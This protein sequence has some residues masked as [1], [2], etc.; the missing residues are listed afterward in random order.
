M[1][2][3]FFTGFAIA[4]LFFAALFAF[5]GMIIS[6]IVAVVMIV[7]ILKEVFKK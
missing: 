3:T 2:E 4:I 6:A 7:R 5:V 1:A